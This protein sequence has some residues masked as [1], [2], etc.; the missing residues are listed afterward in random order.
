MH[1]PRAPHLHALKQILRYIKGTINYGLHLKPS[2]I[3]SLISYSDAG[4]GGCPDTRRS[5][6]SYCV[7]LGDNL[8]SW[9][10][11]RQPTLS[12]SSAEAEYQGVANVVAETCWL[13]NLRSFSNFTVLFPKLLWSIV[14]TSVQSICPAI[15]FN[16]I[17]PNISKWIGYPL[18][19]RKDC[20]RGGSSSSCSIMSSIC[21]YLHQ[22]PSPYFI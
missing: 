12:R 6:S 21:R 2:S 11:K 14:I 22:R 20:S 3:T 13:R 8:L 7:Y 10:S 1:D 9:S 16:I 15:P 17:S 5:T 19:S 18:R 4:W